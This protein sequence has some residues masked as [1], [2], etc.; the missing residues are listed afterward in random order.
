MYLTVNK[1]SDIC[2]QNTPA[3]FLGL[4]RIPVNTKLSTPGGGGGLPNEADGD[5]RRKFWI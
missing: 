1:Q 2:P 5:A 4:I 3:W